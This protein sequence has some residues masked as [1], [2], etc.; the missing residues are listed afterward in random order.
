M[1]CAICYALMFKKPNLDRRISRPHTMGSAF[2]GLMKIFGRV[3][4]DADLAARWD[5]IMG[6]DI[7]SIAKLAAITKTKNKRFNIAVRAANPAFALQLSYQRE[8][9]SQRINKYFG[10][11]AVEKITIRK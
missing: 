11:D 10:F 4:S 9:I 2:G 1:L 3:A 5:E 6:S 7:A 8:E